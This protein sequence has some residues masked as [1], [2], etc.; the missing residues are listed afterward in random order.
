MADAEKDRIE[1][2]AFAKIQSDPELMALV[3]QYASS[4]GPARRRLISQ[5]DALAKQKGI[6]P[7]N[8]RTQYDDGALSGVDHQNWFERN[9]AKLA[10]VAALAPLAFTGIG[11]LAGGGAAASAG[12]TAA[13][14]GASAGAGAGGAIG[15]WLPAIT[16][17]AKLVN[18]ATE[19][20]QASRQNQA[21]YNLSYDAGERARQSVANQSIQTD[22]DQRRYLDDLFAAKSKQAVKG[23]LISGVQDINI[24]RPSGIPSANITGG[25]RPSAVTNKAQIGDAMQRNALMELLNPTQA[26]GIGGTSTGAPGS[27]SLPSIPQLP[28]MSPVSEPNGV[29]TG[30][31]LAGMGLGGLTLLQQLLS[32]S[33]RTVQ[34]VSP[35]IVP[36]RN[37]QPL[38][39]Y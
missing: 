9:G 1:A 4:A 39:L 15:G 22:L 32:D 16:T 3:S 36:L 27:G 7:E 2:E 23:G 12:G 5:I 19:G 25:L 28:A 29:D 17:G 11:A 26:P 31:N 34:P 24:Q 13:G 33:R 38:S 14:A 35:G 21:D 30:L 37:T 10:G 6:L 20:R 18:A 8:Y